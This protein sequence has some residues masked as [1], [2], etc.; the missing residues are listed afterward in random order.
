[1]EEGGQRDHIRK[2]QKKVTECR[3][4]EDG[5]LEWFRLLQDMQGYAAKV[6]PNERVKLS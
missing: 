1:V 6:A 5:L 2:A 3:R 4:G